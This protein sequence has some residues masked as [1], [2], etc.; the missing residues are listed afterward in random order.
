M[1]RRYL[2]LFAIAASAIVF[3]VLRPE[4]VQPQAAPVENVSQFRIVVGLTDTGPKDWQG[5]LSVTGGELVSAR[6]WRFSQQD[7]VDAAG[8]FQ[9]RTKTGPLENQLL[10]AHPY[11][12]TTW[13]DKA[14]QRLI[15]EGLIVK[16]KGAARVRFES[17]AG[18]FEFSASDLPLG[19]IQPL[20]EGNA[21]V[22]SLPIEERIS[23]SGA[24]DDY[25]SLA[26]APDGTRWVSYLS[27]RDSADRVMVSGG[28]K[29]H[30]VAPGGDHQAPAIAADGKGKIWVT[31]SQNDK[32]VFH[33]YARS[34]DGTH[35]SPAQKLTAAGGNNIWPR[36]VSDGQGRLALVW[37]GFRNNQ[38]VILAREYANGAWSAE[39]Q[40]SE[41]PGNC[42]A[43]AA[44]FERG[45][46]WIAWDSYATGSYQ[47]Y[48]RQGAGPVE[49][50]T[51]GE[52]FSVRP[53]IAIAG[54]VPVIAWEESDALWGKDY[55]F[56]FDPRST[57][58]SPASGRN[59]LPLP[60]KR[61]PRT[62]GVS[63]SSPRWPLTMPA[64]C[65]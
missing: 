61:C 25:P 23:E 29:L 19:K 20:L 41:G 51:K 64:I 59:S 34:F 44:A 48:A 38:A 13:G 12:A 10:T 31:W 8:A 1:T 45:K 14:I 24:A 11:G 37:Q 55:T 6:G 54:G 35:W 15:P 7:S 46:L 5:K 2:S 18:A 22:E 40:V 27:Y 32:P 36:L 52:N 3:L 43:P 30:E 58:S 16:V 9:F 33:L 57:V 50:V 21:S 63:S 47:V 62:G 60:R 65:I 17:A 4:P 39:R 53:S 42:W 56:L 49:R 28:G 26:I